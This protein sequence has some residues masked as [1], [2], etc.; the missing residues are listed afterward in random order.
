MAAAASGNTQ[1][2]Q[3]LLEAGMATVLAGTVRTR[4]IPDALH[5]VHH[6]GASPTHANASGETALIIACKNGCEAAVEELLAW[7]QTEVGGPA[8][9]PA[10][11]TLASC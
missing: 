6:A 3:C 5:V 7:A 11:E 2:M 9:V 10:G 4:V 8:G 1:A